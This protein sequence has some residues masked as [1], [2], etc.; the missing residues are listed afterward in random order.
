MKGT[1]FK[2]KLTGM[3]SISIWMA[4]RTKDNGFKINKKGM[5]RKIGLMVQHLKALMFKAKNRDKADSPGMTAVIM[6]E[7]FMITIY[8]ETALI[9]GLM[10]G[11]IQALG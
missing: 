9:L 3:A 5:V 11:Y 7:I 10:E 1:G 2:T 6:R 8:R 4:Q